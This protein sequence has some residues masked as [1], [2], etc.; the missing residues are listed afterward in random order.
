MLV[1]RK[2]SSSA[3]QFFQMLDLLSDKKKLK[4]AIDELKAATLEYDEAAEKY[5][6]TVLKAKGL[7]T[8]EQ[9]EAEV[10]SIRASADLYNSS[11]RKDADNYASEK[12]NIADAR[13]SQLTTDAVVLENTRQQ[14]YQERDETTSKINQRVDDQ[15]KRTEALDARES[16]LIERE[17]AV[18]RKEKLFS[19]V[20]IQLTEKSDGADVS[21]QQ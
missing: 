8:L 6:L 4:T 7:E 10:A 20:T 13:T 19:Q 11:T 21:V 15:D 17:V 9:I 16:K 18:T 2:V 5:D 14:F 3:E 1:G 12:H